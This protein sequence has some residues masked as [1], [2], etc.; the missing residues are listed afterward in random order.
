MRLRATSVTGPLTDPRIHPIWS[1]KG[2]YVIKAL[3][4]MGNRAS[5]VMRGPV[6]RIRTARTGPR[7][8]PDALNRRDFR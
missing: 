8:P 6:N 7:T 1:M 3:N 4:F 2:F 5:M